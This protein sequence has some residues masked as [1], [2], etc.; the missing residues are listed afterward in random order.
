MLDE[1][2]LEQMKQPLEALPCRIVL[3]T[4]WKDFFN[5]RGPLLMQGS[6]KDIRRFVRSHFPVRVL[7]ELDSTLPV[8]PR[9]REEHVVLMKNIS[10]EGAAF[11]HCSQL[12]PGERVQLSLPTGTRRYT[13]LRCLRHN[14]SCYEIGARLADLG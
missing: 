11:L 4:A 14:D 12:Y 5:Q 2:G 3:P 1:S 9:R 10:R 7:M 6:G 8:I 13:V